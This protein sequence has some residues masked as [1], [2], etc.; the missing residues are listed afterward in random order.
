MGFVL[1]NISYAVTVPLWLTLHII[2]SPVSKRFSESEANSVLLVLTLDLRILPISVI[3]GFILPSVLMILPSPEV[4]SS[5][6]HQIYIAIWQLFPLWTVAIHISLRIIC[7][8]VSATKIIK[9]S[10]KGPAILTASYLNNVKY[11]YGFALGMCA[12]T[13]A[14]VLLLTLLPQTIFTHLSPILSRFGK[15]SFRETFLPYIPSQSKQVSSLAEGVITFLQWDI[16]IGSTALLLWSVLLSR[17]AV[18]KRNVGTNTSLSKYPE[19]H[20]REEDD[21]RE[22]RGRWLAKVAIWFLISGPIGVV[23]LLLWER[24]EIMRQK[25]KEGI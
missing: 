18:T 5:P 3:L 8:T 21:K 24:D 14:P 11:I 12:L 2:T 13:Q 17:N 19:L 16:Y 7:Q 22:L 15:H 4:V 6:T 23:A 1:Q 20:L 9:D 10:N 25:S